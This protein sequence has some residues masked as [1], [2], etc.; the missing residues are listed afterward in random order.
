V[1]HNLVKASLAERAVKIIKSRLAHYMTKK[2]THRWLEVLPRVTEGYNKSYHRSIKRAPAS[3]KN[4]TRPPYDGNSRASIQ[5]SSGRSGESV[6]STPYNE[7]FATENISQCKLKDYGGEIVA[8]TFYENQ[9][10][11]AYEQQAYL[12]E[13]ILKSRKRGRKKQYLVR[14][15]N[16]GPRYD[17]WINEADVKDI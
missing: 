10:M 12:I 15:K 1:T 2:Q 6:V 9:I 8:G 5:I 16:W 7:R 4:Q 14:W 13:K 17:S 3:V 11:K